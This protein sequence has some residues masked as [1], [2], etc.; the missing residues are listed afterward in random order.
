[1][2][3]QA[4]STA[5]KAATIVAEADAQSATWSYQRDSF[6]SAVAQAQATGAPPPLDG[7]P[8]VDPGGAERERA[9]RLLDQARADVEAAAHRSAARLRTAA[10]TA[11]NEPGL[12]S[13]LWHGVTE[14]GAGAVEA[15]WGMGVFAFK[16]TPVYQVIDPQGYAENL[17]G[18]GKGLVY[19]VQHP[20]EFAKAVA[21]WDTW[22][23]SPGRALGHLVPDLAITLATAGGGAV[24]KGRA[25]ASRLARVGEKVVRRG[26]P[27][28]LYA[29]RAMRTNAELLGSGAGLSR[30]DATV[31]RVAGKAEV[32]L[33]DVAVRIM[34][35][36]EYVRYLDH[37]GACACTPPELGGREIHLGPA[38]FSDEET[39]AATLAHERVHVSQLRDGRHV[40]SAS[41]DD[42]EA[43][44]RAAE[45]DALRRLEGGR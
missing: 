5:A 44:A 4:Q 40:S 34:E 11:P 17:L 16:L 19:G 2:L 30:T 35:D 12:L 27:A 24:L 45:P 20:V 38:A 25:A 3:R 31:A 6:Q 37:H 18:L 9:A 28:V 41:L 15:T 21:D 29:R 39:L 36:Q 26:E 23:E 8:A 1:M 22:A 33:K 13:K 42:L 10:A 43:E 14:F 7:P 32:D